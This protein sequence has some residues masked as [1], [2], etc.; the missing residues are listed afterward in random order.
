MRPSLR[1]LAVAVVGWAGFRIATLG[2][3]PDARMFWRQPDAA[4]AP[5]ITQT[6][7][8]AV[9]PIQP[10]TPIMRDPQP[11]PQAL[12]S[13][14]AAPVQYV[15]GTVGVPVAMRPGVVTV[16]QLPPATRA[17]AALA[18]QAP[19]TSAATAPPIFNPAG[20]SVFPPLAQGP[21]SLVSTATAPVS[22]PAAS[23]PGESVPLLEQPRVKRLQLT[24]WALL[25]RQRTGIAGSQSLAP[26]GQLGA[27]QAGARLLYS[28]NR[29]IALSARLSSPVGTRGGE[30]AAG[31]RIQPLVNFPVWLTAERRQAI[32]RF[33]G[34]RSAFALFIES[35]VYEQPLPWRFALD[36]YFQSG[37]VGMKRHDLFVDGG[38]TVTRP[39]FKRV[40]AG[41][42]VWGGAQPHLARLDV[43]PR[44]TLRVRNNMKMHLDWREK[45]A[46]NARPGS[47]P[48]LTLAGDF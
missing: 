46:G 24:S 13:P 43:G 33:G 11:P 35:G 36:S 16:Y 15:K 40:S 1:F 18:L 44:I 4:K 32:G 14:A 19:G 20:Y 23:V 28:F 2:A 21:L 34:G 38:L 48:A 22:R 25:R 8:P 7:F 5:A 45:V 26:I 10:A 29:R 41:F 6:N 47:G 9:E 12:S 39:L 27:S 3:L 37:V 30:G 42:G 31:V 17:V